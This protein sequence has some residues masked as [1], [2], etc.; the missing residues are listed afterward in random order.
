MLKNEAEVLASLVRLLLHTKFFF[1]PYTGGLLLG[2]MGKAAWAHAGDI[3]G[4]LQNRS[5]VKMSFDWPNLSLVIREK[6]KP[7]NKKG[8]MEFHSNFRCVSSSLCVGREKTASFSKRR[9]LL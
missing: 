4:Q 3:A 7:A 8:A 9:T 1:P 6:T 5:V 2:E